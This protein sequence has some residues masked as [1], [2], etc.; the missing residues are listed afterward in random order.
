MPLDSFFVHKP[1]VLSGRGARSEDS[2]AASALTAL[3]S[4][5]STEALEPLR[6]ED[7][8]FEALK[9]TINNDGLNDLKLADKKEFSSKIQK[10]KKRWVLKVQHLIGVFFRFS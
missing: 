7:W 3:T 9:A 10:K 1:I 5:R 2:E 4:R 6:W 8:A